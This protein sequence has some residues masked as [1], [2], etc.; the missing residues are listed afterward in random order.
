MLAVCIP[1]F[2]RPDMLRV[3]LRYVRELQ[4]PP[5]CRIQIIV[6]DNDEHGGSRHVY[7]ASGIA[8]TFDAVYVTESD[9]GL[10]Q[11]RNRCL[12]TARQMGARFIGFV[13]DDE[14]PDPAWLVI[15]RS[16]MLERD[17]A[18]VRGPVMQIPFED[19]QAVD[20]AAQIPKT[21][22]KTGRPL[23]YVSANN[24]LFEVDLPGGEAIR[25]DPFY[26]LTAGEDHDFFNRFMA[27][28]GAG[29]VWCAEA[30]VYE[31]LPSAQR[32]TKARLKRA[33]EGATANVI[34]YRH[35]HA[36]LPT[37]LHFL[38]KLLG[39][40]FTGLGKCLAA[41]L[42]GRKIWVAGLRDLVSAAGYLA[43]LMGQ[44]SKF[45]HNIRGR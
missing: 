7:E 31:L 9:R 11:V 22:R 40:I 4:T 17:V 29:A 3:C 28:T 39:K 37:W 44:D 5:G 23:K 18:I 33:F 13:D 26:K 38:L 1:T 6:V 19:Y 30:R 32:A 36:A 35:S 2:K 24:V 21:R 15:L 16:V 10:A 45:Y 14:F 42:L 25:F 27:A 8:E 20:L 41:A 12:E 43:G 34:K